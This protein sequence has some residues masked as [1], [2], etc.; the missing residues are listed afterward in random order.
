[1]AADAVAKAQTRGEV[2]STSADGKAVDRAR[3][4]PL[5]E[6]ALVLVSPAPA[7]PG[8]APGGR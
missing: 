4:G 6:D 5:Q 2:V 8:D 1:M 3:L 7:L